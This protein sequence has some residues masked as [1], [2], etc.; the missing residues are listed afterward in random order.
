VTS[1][2]LVTPRT[3]PTSAVRPESSDSAPLTGGA[4]PEN[5]GH[6]SRYF[7]L[8][9]LRSRLSLI[10]LNTGGIFSSTDLTEWLG[11]FHAVS[12]TVRGAADDVAAWSA[13]E[14]RG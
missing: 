9:P 5:S 8:A 12:P 10:F 13:A 1:S 2:G 14:Q 7:D 6:E 11:I 3:Q 4:R